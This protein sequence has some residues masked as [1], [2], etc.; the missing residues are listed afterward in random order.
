[1]VVTM[2]DG[3][4]IND[5]SCV[6]FLKWSQEIDRFLNFFCPIPSA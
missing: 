6:T 3:L 5:T 4:I 2:M 1:M